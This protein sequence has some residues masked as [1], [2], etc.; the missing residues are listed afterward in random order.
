LGPPTPAAN[1][2]IAAYANSDESTVVA[3]TTTDAKGN[4]TLV[5]PSSTPL[6]GYLKATSAPNADVPYS[7]TYLYPPVPLTADFANAAINMIPQSLFSTLS[8]VIGMAQPGQG[9]VALE[10]IDSLASMTFISGATVA[11]D[12]PSNPPKIS[13]D[14][15][16]SSTPSIVNSGGP[17]ATGGD[18]RGFI[19]ALDPGTYTV[20]AAKT[21]VTFKPTTVKV[22]AN[23]FTTTLVTE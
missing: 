20:T 17:T 8:G 22:F 7:D 16:G 21:G 12:P 13:Y 9:V 3:M 5:V 14:A 19:F 18:G 15:Q 10:V 6:D 2:I 23:A 1:V 4:Y 11:S